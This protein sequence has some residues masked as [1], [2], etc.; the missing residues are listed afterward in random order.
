MAAEPT[1]RAVLG[2][3]A[4]ATACAYL[5]RRGLQLVE[6]NYRCAH[7]EIDLVMRERETLV[8]VEVRYRTG[9]GF[10]GAAA[11]VDARKQARLTA[12]ALHYLQRHPGAR[13]RECRFDVVAVAPGACE[14]AV[15]WIQAAF[16]AR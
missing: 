14:D 16:D 15:E 1:A 10:G 9:A 11:S 7:G 3:R 2:T 6:R 13:K 8:F 4:E 5:Q 12:T